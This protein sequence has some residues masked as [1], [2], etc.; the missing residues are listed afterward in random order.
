MPGRV[1]KSG[2]YEWS[3]NVQ[4]Y[5]SG[6]YLR[7]NIAQ[8]CHVKGTLFAP[9]FRADGYGRLGV[10]EVATTSD[11]LSF[12]NDIL[13][14]F[15]ILH[16]SQFT[17]CRPEE[18]KPSVSAALADIFHMLDT[19]RQRSAAEIKSMCASVPCRVHFSSGE[20]SLK[21]EDRTLVAPHEAFTINGR[22]RSLSCFGVFDGHGGAACAAF[23]QANMLPAVRDALVNAG[24]G[25]D[26]DGDDT[27]VLNALVNGFHSVD[28]AFVQSGGKVGSTATLVLVDNWKLTVAGVGDSRC[29]LVLPDGSVREL[30]S[31]HRCTNKAEQVRVMD[32]G[33]LVG[34]A[35]G[36]NGQDVG[37]L[38]IWPGGIALTRALGDPEMGA[39][40]LSTPSIAQYDVPACPARLILASDG[41]WDALESEEVAQLTVGVGTKDVPQLLINASLRKIGRNDD[42]SVVVVD[43]FPELGEPWPDNACPLP[44]SKKKGTFLTR[45]RGKGK[46]KESTADGS[47]Q[48]N[49][50]KSEE[51]L[52]RSDQRVCPRVSTMQVGGVMCTECGI[53]RLVEDMDF[54]HHSCG[55]NSFCRVH[56]QS[57]IILSPQ[58]VSMVSRGEIKLA[59]LIARHKAVIGGTKF[60]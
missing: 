21:G 16:A 31:D 17:I 15:S 1:W 4:F 23:A 47:T 38:R 7:R 46:E 30:T 50:H 52:V 20:F 5:D 19:L 9:L 6:T 18:V 24:E 12:Q 45:L 33:A 59:E 2:M 3:P 32:A 29:I 10:L 26:E 34:Q 39:Y 28:A 51:A 27:A 54:S 55:Q 44:K 22:S 57:Q 36:E 35:F 37:S 41:L 49:L 42:I 43:L 60:K 40:I 13:H 11:H 8:K 53:L 48:W 56:P 25:D 14:I 58:Q